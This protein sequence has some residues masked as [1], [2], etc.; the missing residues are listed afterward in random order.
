[1]ARW[2]PAFLLLIGLPAAAGAQVTPDTPATDTTTVAIPATGVSPDTLP[3][4][5]LMRSA[6]DS[7]S[8]PVFPRFPNRLPTGWSHGRWE[9][10]PEELRAYFGLTLL[11][12]LERVPGLT[13]VRA[14]DTGYPVGITALGLG[15]GRV[16]VVLDGYELDPLGFTSPDVQQLGT[17]DLESIRL[18]RE[19]TGIRL[20][21]TTVRLPAGRP[22]SVVEAG[23]G[24]YDSKFVR[25]VLARGVGGRSIITAAYDAVSTDG[26]AFDSPFALAAARIA[27]SY[28]FSERSA[29]QAELRSSGFDR[30]E[31]A[32]AE[33]ADQRTILLRGRTQVAPGLLL[34]A[35][36]GRTTRSPAEADLLTRTL[37]ST[38]ALVRASYD[39]PLAWSE[40]S[41][42]LRDSE[43][44]VSS[45][46]PL[47]LTARAAIT[48][49][50]RLSA[51]GELRYA[52]LGDASGIGWRATARAGF[53]SAAL[54]AG[55]SGGEAALGVVRD[56]AYQ[57][58]SGGSADARREPVFAA[59]GASVGALRV[60]AEWARGGLALGAAGVA[61]PAGR[62][63]PFGVAF[64]R[65]LG[66]VEVEAATGVEGYAAFGVPLTGGFARAEG[67]VGYWSDTGERPFLPG[68]DARGAFLLGGLFFDGQLEPRLRF[69]VAH[70]GAMLVRASGSPTAIE[71]RPHTLTNLLL[72]IRII[73]VQ[74]FG[75]WENFLNERDAADLPGSPLPGSRLVYG[76]RWVFRN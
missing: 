27:W 67:S 75:A 22:H 10:G 37:A 13:V 72:Q 35:A 29:L 54:F 34:D 30:A 57:V 65:G 4:D 49:G 33:A 42:R 44:E 41:A 28:A 69:E 55:L 59:V 17:I 31:G 56:T 5:S 8:A 40:L 73:D 51:D 9:W 68:L 20:E 24:M 25:G 23:T 71:S 50:G 48:P 52:P 63:V 64:D 47:D 45:A 76:I 16:R 58:P 39:S 46:P 66:A 74:A 32:G 36:I 14:G 11:Q 7:T 2:L 38:Q 1:M 26:F 21:L 70:R 60:G 62:V 6:G 61:L 3:G 15:G 43:L 53:G 18:D 19:A 12:F